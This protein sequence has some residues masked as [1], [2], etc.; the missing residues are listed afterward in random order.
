MSRPLND[1]ELRDI[2]ENSLMFPEMKK[3]PTERGAVMSPR[4]ARQ[5]DNTVLYLITYV[6]LLF[7]VVVVCVMTG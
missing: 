4:R 3:Q 1:D 2:E 7:L 5:L 6:P